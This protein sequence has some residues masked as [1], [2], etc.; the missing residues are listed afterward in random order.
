MVITRAP[1]AG[2]VGRP[3]LALVMLLVMPPAERRVSTWLKAWGE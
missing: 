1:S 2:P 3:K